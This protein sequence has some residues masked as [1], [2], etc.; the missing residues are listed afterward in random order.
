MSVGD[1]LTSD[2]P[3]TSFTTSNILKY[4]NI[5]GVGFF[6]FA[7]ETVQ[8]IAICVSIQQNYIV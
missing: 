2:P 1:P 6:I 4:T 5:S 7:V 8:I 3:R